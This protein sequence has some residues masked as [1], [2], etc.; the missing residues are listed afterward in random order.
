MTTYLP[1][2]NRLPSMKKSRAR[3]ATTRMP[4]MTQLDVARRAGIAQM[5]APLTTPRN[6]NLRMRA[7]VPPNREIS[8]CISTDAP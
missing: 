2:T 4:S 1:G 8:S 6:T 5:A 3:V 7:G